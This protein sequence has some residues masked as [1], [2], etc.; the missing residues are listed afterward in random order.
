MGIFRRFFFF[1]VVNIL[2]VTSAAIVASIVMRY[3]GITGELPFYAI[4][5]S[6]IGFGG[7][8]FSLWI[9]KWTAKKMMGVKVIDPRTNSP[10]EAD[11]VQ[12]VHELA[13]AARLKKMP[14]VGIYESQDLNAFA[15]GPSKNNSLVACSR[16][17][18]NSLNKEELRGVLGHEVAHIVNGDM[19]T[20]TLLQGLINTMVLILARLAARA[21]MSRQRS[22]S[23]MMESLIFIG[24][25]MVF[26]ILGSVVLCYFSRKREY[27]ADAGGAKLAGSNSM[28]QA[29]KAL[30]RNYMP[31][32]AEQATSKHAQSYG[33]L[34]IS[35]EKKTNWFSTHPPLEVRIE[36]LER[37]YN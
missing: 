3:F 26:S 27:R 8:F 4:L 33:Y 9:S 34:K 35:G 18:L 21:I 17:L 32:P 23:Y 13:R 37:N 12:T 2:I 20:M 15:T 11:L 10:Q 25:Q 29:L 16:G 36:R 14:E 24:L 7:A 5:Y 1:I 31:Q 19:V 30:Q 6:L 28:I 22:R